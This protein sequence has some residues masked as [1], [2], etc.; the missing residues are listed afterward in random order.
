MKRLQ[1][2]ATAVSITL[3]TL[4]AADTFV[5]VHGA[6]QTAS[7]WDAVSERLEAKGHAV[8]AVNLPGRNA[9]GE[10]ASLVS[11]SAYIDIVAEAVTAAGEPV[12]L[13]GH[14]FGGMTITGVADRKPEAIDHLVYVAAYVPRSGESMEV[15]ALSDGDN[16][17]TE[18]TFVVAPDYSY[19]EILAD[20]QVRVFAQDATPQQ[21]L[22]LQASMVRE[23]LAPIGTSIELAG[24]W[25]VPVETAYVRTTDDGTV[26]TPLQTMMIDRAGITDVRD[27]ETGHAPFLTQPEA[28]ADILASIAE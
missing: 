14:S 18:A 3:P 17:F 2:L 27:I 24:D 5:L 11:L 15:L 7:S 21:A 8:V 28:L 23:P 12:I 16:R 13:V 25:P 1:T 9:A 26:S 20:D 4:A 10:E 19:A 6:F 22:A